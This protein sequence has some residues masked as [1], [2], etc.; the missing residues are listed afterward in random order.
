MRD[1]YGEYVRFG[2]PIGGVVTMLTNEYRDALFS[3]FPISRTVFIFITIWLHRAMVSQMMPR[4]PQI[5]IATQQRK[6]QIIIP[7]GS[8]ILVHRS[9]IC[10]C[11]K[12]QKAMFV[13]L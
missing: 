6:I 8:A 2:V 7:T 3:S 1:A 9:S 5:I 13:L 11:L 12:D 10:A 4:V